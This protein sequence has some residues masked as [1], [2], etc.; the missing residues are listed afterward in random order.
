MEL[1]DV[2][3]GTMQDSPLSLLFSLFTERLQLVGSPVDPGSLFG[4]YF[5]DSN[6]FKFD[7]ECAPLHNVNCDDN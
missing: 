5:V 7:W 1:V 2:H 6:Y 3:G 4:N